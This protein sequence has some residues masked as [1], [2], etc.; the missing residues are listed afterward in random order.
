M[1]I[2]FTLLKNI[3]LLL[4][5][6][7][8][9]LGLLFARLEWVVFPYFLIF[10]LL[11]PWWRKLW[12]WFLLAGLLFGGFSLVWQQQQTR[13]HDSWLGQKIHIQAQIH[14]IRHTAQYTRLR[15]ENVQRDD[16]NKLDALI[17]VYVY[18][19]QLKLLP[20]MQIAATVKLHR[21]HNKKNPAYFDYVQYMFTQGVAA[22]GSVSGS[23]EVLH[24]QVSWLTLARQHI[25]QALSGLDKNQQ[26]ILLALL[27]ADRSQIPL[28]IDD[29]FAASGVT[30]L[31]AISGLHM[32]LVAGWFF[33]LAWWLM[34]RRE[35]WI[36][37]FPVRLVA[38]SAGVLLAF[39]Y[40]LLAGFPIPAQRAFLMLLAG[41]IAWLTRASQV[42][43]NTMFVALLLITM[44]DPAS[45]LSISLWLSFVA[46]SALIIWAGQQ[47]ATKSMLAQAWLWF[48][49]MFWVSV[50]ASLATLPLIGY[51]FERLPTWSL[52]ANVVLVPLYALWVL[53]LALLGELLALLGL[54]AWASTVF[55]WSAVGIEQG[56]QY[57][58]WIQDLPLADVWLRADMP[59]LFVVLGLLLLVVGVLWLQARRIAAASLLLVGL[60]AYVWLGLSEA[61]VVRP[62]LHVWDVG[63]GAS[64][65]L[66]L[67][68]FQLLVDAPGKRGSKYNGGSI[69][70]QNMRH[71]GLL[72][73]DAM[74][75]SHAQSDHAGGLSRLL[76]NLNGVGAL[77]LADVPKNRMYFKD[78]LDKYP[79]QWL[80]KGDVL[81]LGQ[82][83]HMQV[84]WP[85]QGY[86]PKNN[87]NASLVL[88][89]SFSDGQTLLLMG[90]AEAPVERA[91]LA[92]Q[93]AENLKAIDVM[94]M[95][96]HGSKTS[97]TTHFVNQVR[98]KLVI[99]Q[100][101]Y[102]NHYGFPKDEVVKRYQDVGSQ[103]LDTA[104]GAVRVIFEDGHL[105]IE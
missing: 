74:V 37:R 4:P 57:L 10:L 98:P 91:L 100:T 38:L 50:I 73:V 88:R 72:H 2:L 25:R 41:V 23:I 68:D 15:L 19:Q 29:T 65:L 85:P 49:G 102:Q 44:F 79:V 84:L 105:N 97:S 80:K 5:S 62:K 89:V 13:V 40:A 83:V 48:K 45:V 69:A 103:V 16:G 95:P 54:S 9:V 94:L 81:T 35:A 28:S 76:A 104:D 14:D 59:W 63:Q 101:G 77:W 21:P 86:A 52:L 92:S 66:S 78:I 75:I 43:L 82:G 24:Q 6:L 56:N 42:P 3:P 47:A 17:D 70:A 20:D 18:H 93:D 61:E 12:F 90:D 11:L 30:H 39:T 26:G 36:V 32:G 1:G 55:S 46:T 53:P 58:L 96:H 7:A 99:A 60:S 8:W 87:N 64:A 33:L 22:S 31:L 34:T 71:L 51:V 27:L 67:P